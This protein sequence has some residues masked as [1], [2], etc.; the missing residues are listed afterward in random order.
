MF[1]ENKNKNTGKNFEINKYV[2]EGG[3]IFY[4]YLYKAAYPHNHPPPTSH[5]LYS[6]VFCRY[7]INIQREINEI[8]F[9]FYLLIFFF[10]WEKKGKFFI[11]V[12][13]VL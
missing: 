9:N 2:G 1:Q 13:K 8:D 4:V 5:V 11:L 12:A 10:F 7:I 6:S 3:N